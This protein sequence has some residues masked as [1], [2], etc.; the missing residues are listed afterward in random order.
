MSDRTCVFC[1]KKSSC[2]EVKTEA[3]VL[4]FCGW[5]CLFAYALSQ[6][7]EADDEQKTVIEKL[8]GKIKELEH[9]IVL[10]RTGSLGQ[11]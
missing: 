5:T 2:I 7:K 3:A 6:V 8:Q 11:G 9:T 10:Y 1:E 4:E